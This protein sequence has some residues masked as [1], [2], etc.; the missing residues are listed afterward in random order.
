MA[1]H[2]AVRDRLFAGDAQSAES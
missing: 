2:D 1:R